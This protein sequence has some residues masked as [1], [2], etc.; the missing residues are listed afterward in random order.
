MVGVGR[1]L[2]ISSCPIPTKAQSPTG[3]GT[4]FFPGVFL[5]Y[6]GKET[7]QPLGHAV[8]VLH[9]VKGHV[10]AL[11]YTMLRDPFLGRCPGA[12]GVCTCFLLPFSHLSPSLQA[13]VSTPG[14]KSPSVFPAQAAG[15]TCLSHW[16]RRCGLLEEMG[17]S[18]ELK[19]GGS[20]AG[21]P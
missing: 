12:F 2:W 10:L 14:H 16:C 1:H 7:P 5:I 15:V 13:R 8:A 11:L 20:A 18:Q 19:H 6:P 9:H 4:G 21:S 17:A 3:G